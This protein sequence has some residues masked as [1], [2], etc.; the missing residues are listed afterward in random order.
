[1]QCVKD[2]ADFITETK[3]GQGAVREVVELILG[4]K[5]NINEV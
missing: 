4:Q 3:G 1:M 2:V 5:G